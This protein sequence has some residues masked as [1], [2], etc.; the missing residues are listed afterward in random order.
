MLH[1]NNRSILSVFTTVCLLLFYRTQILTYNFIYFTYSYL[2][3][4]GYVVPS[5]EYH[6]E[7]IKW[8]DENSCG[9]RVR[10]VVLAPGILSS[11]STRSRYLTLYIYTFVSV[12]CSRFVHHTTCV[13][14]DPSFC[15]KHMIKQ[16]M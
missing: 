12:Q 9:V 2:Q 11:N 10:V 3:R 4:A 15:Q 7:N 6:L 5:S 1:V 14:N 16:T 8:Y 13:I